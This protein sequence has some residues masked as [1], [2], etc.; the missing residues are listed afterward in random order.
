MNQQIAAERR[1][2]LN[3]ARV[4]Q[5]AVALADEVGIGPLS[6]RRLAQELDVVPMALYK[7]VANKEELLD[8]MVDVIIGEIDPPVAGADWKNMVRL[9]VLSARRG[10]SA[11]SGPGASW[12]LAPTRLPPSWA[13]W[14]RSSACSSPGLFRGSDASRDACHRKPDVGLHAGTV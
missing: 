7:H 9:R 6:M 3:R 14:T 13:T 12:K 11:T 2:R 5:A 4:L 10:S 8:G 1:P